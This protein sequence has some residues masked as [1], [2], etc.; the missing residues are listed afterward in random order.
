MNEFEQ[1]DNKI[2]QEQFVFQEHPDYKCVAGFLKDEIQLQ[3]ISSREEYT[4]WE[5]NEC[6]EIIKS[7]NN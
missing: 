6:L 2:L 5:I 7:Y 3:E 4:N 1:N